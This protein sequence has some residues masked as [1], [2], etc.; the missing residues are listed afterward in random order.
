MPAPDI[1]QTVCFIWYES[2]DIIEGM[3]KV[4]LSTTSYMVLGL[5]AL[6]GPSTPYDLKRAVGHS[7]GYFW[8]FPH[9]QLYS[10]PRRLREA[11]LLDLDQEDSGRR[12]MIYS[13]TDQGMAALRDWLAE[14]VNT[15][16]ELRDVAEIKLFFKE[17]ISQHERRIAEYEVMEHKYRD[18][19]EVAT[20]M[21]TIELGFEMERAALG[22]WHRIADRVEHG[23][24]PK[25]ADTRDR[26]LGSR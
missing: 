22:F 5:I 15:H 21:I 3:S 8:T 24:F 2:Y 12:R 14:P 26:H 16:F 25:P 7:I 9:A 4:R 23:E 11:G 20:R 1:L 10:E 13:I 19:P 6:R 18:V 17:Q